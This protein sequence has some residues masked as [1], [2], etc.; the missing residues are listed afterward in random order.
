MRKIPVRG[1]VLLLLTSMVA[2][3]RPYAL[4]QRTP[5]DHYAAKQAA[6]PTASADI[7]VDTTR[8]DIA[9]EA[10]PA[11][12][13]TPEAVATVDRQL[14]TSSA[15]KQVQRRLQHI[16]RLLNVS[17]N[18]PVSEPQQPRPRPKTQKKGMTLREF[19]G[20]PEKKPKTAWE[21]INWNLKAG[22]V[23]VLFAIVFALLKINLLAIL[24]G[25][26]AILIL[27]R[28]MRKTWKGGGFLGL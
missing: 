13:V 23:L 27:L 20:L 6:A 22:V 17:A 9:F 8:A 24:F 4:L 3:H 19:F 26:F 15:N 11:E 14:T 7:P 28:G 18:T 21:R 2:C 12:P 1:L 25:I 10:L 5:T 16:Q